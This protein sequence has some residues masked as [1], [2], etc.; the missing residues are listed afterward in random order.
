MLNGAMLHEQLTNYFDFL[1]LQKYKKQQNNQFK[2]EMNAYRK[3]YTYYINHYQELIPQLSI[4]NPN[5]IP[6]QW[7]SYNRYSI[8]PEAKKSSIKNGFEIWVRWERDTKK[9]YESLYNNL[10]NIN[11][12]AGAE[13]VRKLIKDVDNELKNAEQELINLIA[14]EFDLTV[15]IPEQE[16]GAD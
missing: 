7:Y 8:N 14:I 4:D 2:D 16:N 5:I 6:P 11:D 10:L 9:L 12:V 3:I 1:N 13:Q 15:I